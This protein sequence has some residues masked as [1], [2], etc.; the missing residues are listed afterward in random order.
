M[1]KKN[2]LIIALLSISLTAT[3][4]GEVATLKNG[5]EK[6]VSIGDKDGISADSYYDSIKYS[7]IA[8]LVDL[9]DADILKDIESTEEEDEYVANQIEQI[10]ASYENDQAAFETAISQYFGASNEKE[11][12]EV[13]RLEYKRNEAVE[14]HI[15][16]NIDEKEIEQYYEDNIHGELSAKHILIIPDVEDDA[17]AEEKTKA[18]EKAEEEAKDLIKK[19]DDGEDFEDLAKKY[20][21]DEGTATNGGDLGFFSPDEMDDNFSEAALE[22]K[23]GK[24]S[25]EPVKSQFGYHIILKVDEKE[26]PSLED[27]EDNIKSSIAQSKLLTDPSLVYTTLMAI[28]DEHDVKFEDDELKKEYE[29]FMDSLISSANTPTT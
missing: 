4:C 14:K 21:D 16:D 15:S 27:E 25:S 13:L 6:V 1:K 26:K 19:L 23:K 7:Q 10:K 17:S 22:L 3:G 20:S 24:Y 28:R 8:K 12:E 9:I 5:E 29:D 11:L 2:L 18:E